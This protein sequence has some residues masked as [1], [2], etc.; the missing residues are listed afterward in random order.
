MPAFFNGRELLPA[1]ACPQNI[2]AEE[3]MK[4]PYRGPQRLSLR[5]LVTLAFLLFALTS[6]S[7]AELRGSWVN[8]IT[9][10]INDVTLSAPA[11][12]IIGKRPFKEGDTVKAGALIIEL[13]KKLEELEVGRRKYVV[14]LKK[15]DMETSKKIFEKTISLSR[16][17]MEKKVMEYSVAEA[18]HAL[19]MEL[20]QRRLIIAPFEGTIAA[21]TLQVGEAC[22]AQQALVRLV[23]TRTCYFICNIE[24]KAGYALK[25]GQSVKLEVEAGEKPVPFDGTV[26]FVSPVVDPASGLM[27][28]KVVF[29]NAAGKIRPGAAGR[30]LLQENKD[31]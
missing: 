7:S 30:M 21:L 23:D 13:D 9:E 19:A 10:A 1:G 20:L 18:E 27:R 28:V 22:Q 3:N 8:G 25:P 15:T 2:T 24:A 17:E 4:S 5:M 16:E 6:A 12:G 29:D 26:F 11:A 14:D 31:A